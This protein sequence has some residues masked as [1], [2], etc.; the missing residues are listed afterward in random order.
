VQHKLNQTVATRLEPRDR[1]Y[2]RFDRTPPGF[3]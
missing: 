1:P 2:I 3:G